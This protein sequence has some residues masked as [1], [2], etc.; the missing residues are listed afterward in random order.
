VM[1]RRR[2]VGCAVGEHPFIANRTLIEYSRARVTKDSVLE[3]LRVGGSVTDV[4]AAEQRFVEKD[5]G[6]CHGVDDTQDRFCGH[7]RE[8][9]TGGL[10]NAKKRRG[11]GPRSFDEMSHRL[12]W[13]MLS[14]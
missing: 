3:A 14:E 2:E 7:S 6:M 5:S 4:A 1:G 13:D 9:G 8:S 10:E 11:E 12:F